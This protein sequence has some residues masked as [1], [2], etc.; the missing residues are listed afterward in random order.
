M[1]IH[2]YEKAFLT[3]GGG[4]LVACTAALI[5]ATIA[6]G[7]HLPG[8]SGRID[9]AQVMVTPP[10]DRPGVYRRAGDEYEVV[11]VGRAWSFQPAEIRVPA[12]ADITFTATSVD[13]L[14][15]FNI[16]GTRLNMM[17]IPGQI[18]RNEYRFD[19]PGEHLL[20][21]HEYCGLGHHLMYGRIVVEPAGT[22]VPLIGEEPPLAGQ[23]N[24]DPPASPLAPAMSAPLQETVLAHPSSH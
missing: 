16:E 10:F 11:A 20:I 17:L 22:A 6:H 5:Y 9:P 3:V 24:N 7:I 12:G 18:S 19:E 21:C 15:G 8:A 4:V 1:K 14:H 2:S 13:V 23:P